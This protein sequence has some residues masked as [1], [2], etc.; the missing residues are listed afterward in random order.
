MAV[1]SVDLAYRRWSD[2][3][4]VVLG[5]AAATQAQELAISALAPVFP[6]KVFDGHER[7]DGREWMPTAPGAI[8]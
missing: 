6:S 3:G 7:A 1:L 5:R 4:I 8:V 2:V